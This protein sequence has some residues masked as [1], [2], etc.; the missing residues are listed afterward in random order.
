MVN[1]IYHKSSYMEKNKM[2]SHMITSSLT[3]GFGGSMGLEAPIELPVWH[4]D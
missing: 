2:Y 4:L 3:V 1:N